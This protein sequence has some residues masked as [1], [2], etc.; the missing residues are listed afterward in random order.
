MKKRSKSPDDFDSPWKDA[1][2]LYFRPFLG[3]LFP[4]LHTDIDWSKGYEALDKEFQQIIRRAKVGKGLADKLFKVWLRDGNECWL[5]IH[6]EVQGNCDPKFPERM[7]RYNVAAYSVYNQEVVSLAVLC[8]E[9]PNWRP[10]TFSYGRWGFRTSIQFAI[11]KLLDHDIDSLEKSNNPFA[12]I[13]IAHLEALATHWYRSE[14]RRRD[15]ERDVW[16]VHAQT[17]NG[18]HGLGELAQEALTRLPREQ[19]Q[20]VV[21]KIWGGLTFEEIG[22]SLDIPPNTAASRYRYALDALRSSLQ[23]AK[24]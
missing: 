24:R 5:V 18:S 12:A 7:F 13:V 2:Q 15:R 9:N 14:R 8:D 21:M 16:F 22:A 20:V 6:V 11:A 17:G 1:L 23:E 10:D 3:L 4:A 19:R